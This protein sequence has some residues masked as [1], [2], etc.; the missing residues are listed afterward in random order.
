MGCMQNHQ[1][2]L[3]KNFLM[4]L[5]VDREMLTSSFEVDSQAPK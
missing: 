3:K 2:D 5:P 4:C 1:R